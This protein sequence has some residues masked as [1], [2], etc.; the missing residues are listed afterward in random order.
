LS[1]LRPR[2]RPLVGNEK[3]VFDLK[4]SKKVSGKGGGERILACQIQ[5]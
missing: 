1:Q 4:F 2:I 5:G 3:H